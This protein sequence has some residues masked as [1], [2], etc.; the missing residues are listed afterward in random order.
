MNMNELVIQVLS[1]YSQYLRL[2]HARYDKLPQIQRTYNRAIE[3]LREVIEPIEGIV[4][5]DVPG[6]GP[7]LAGSILEI[8]KTGTLNDLEKLVRK[9]GD[10]REILT[11]KGIGIKKAK[12]LKRRFGIK[13][14]RSLDKAIQKGRITDAR[15]VA[16]RLTAD[17]RASWEEAH[18]VFNKVH[19]QLHSRLNG[20]LQYAGSMRRKK[21]TVKDVDLL[22]DDPEIHKVFLTL[23]RPVEK[24]SRK[25]S[26]VLDK[27]CVELNYSHPESWGTAILHNTGHWRFNE[28]LRVT[29]KSKGMLLNEY[30]VQNQDQQVTFTEEQDVFDYLEVDYV[31]PVS[32]R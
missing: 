10:Y 25:S 31:E 18:E 23:G 32:R 5:T 26:I 1:W 19:G 15:I 11:V 22:T 30:C 29:A 17:H 27:I 16:S 28:K 6:I 24:G 21:D 2:K 8:M 20:R 13:D 7:K 14:I 3:R 9:Y 12:D 4:L